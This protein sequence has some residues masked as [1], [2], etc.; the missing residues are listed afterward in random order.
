MDAAEKA[1][2]RE[3]VAQKRADYMANRISHQEYYCWLADFIGLPDGLIPFSNAQ[4]AASKDAHLNDL[5]LHAWDNRHNAVVLY[6]GSKGLAWSLSDTVCCL[7][8][9]ARR[10]AGATILPT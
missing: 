2:N 1:A 7:K 5:P 10:R 6:A 9:I 4:V 8:T 3:L